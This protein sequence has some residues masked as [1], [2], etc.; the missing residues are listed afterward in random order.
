MTDRFG[1]VYAA[2]TI[3]VG[4]PGHEAPY[5]LAYVDVDRGRVLAPVDRRVVVGERVA[6]VDDPSSAT[7]LLA[8]AASA[9]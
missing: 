2:T 5:T 4:L 7:G 9:A 8:T 6:L 1:V 3:H